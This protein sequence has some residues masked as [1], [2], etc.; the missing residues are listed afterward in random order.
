MNPILVWYRPGPGIFKY[1]K[2]LDTIFVLVFRTKVGILKE[3]V[4]SFVLGL[5]KNVGTS[6]SFLNKLL[7]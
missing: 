2:S 4:D 1:D 5:N 6:D 3:P 7:D